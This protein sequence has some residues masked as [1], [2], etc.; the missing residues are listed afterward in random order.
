MIGI[1]TCSPNTHMGQLLAPKL[2]MIQT[3]VGA[4]A[5]SFDS[6]LTLRG[7]RTLQVRM[8]RQCQNALELAMFLE[9]LSLSTSTSTST[10]TSPSPL[11]KITKVHYP[12]LPSHPQHTIA[13][14]QM[15]MYGS[16]ISF[17]VQ[18]CNNNE[19]N[20]N[21]NMNMDMD[22]AMAITGG[23]QLIKRATSLGGTETLI[24]HRASI[25][26]KERIVSPFGL[27][28]MS[29]GLEHIDDL[30]QDLQQAFQI[31]HQVMTKLKS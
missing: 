25:E 19:M 29:V 4:I 31:T 18:G 1:V 10:S 23:L 24:E 22:I 16:I 13:K 6:W 15:T 12:G 30:K 20:M 27:L 14:Q 8:E 17:E 28:R 26:P 9:Q 21:M 11:W 3:N 7:L 5:S 2:K